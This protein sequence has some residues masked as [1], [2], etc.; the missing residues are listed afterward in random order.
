MNNQKIELTGRI[1]TPNSPDYNSAREAFN[2]FFNKFPLIIV[3]TQNTQDV[4]NAVRWS[5]LHNVPMRMRSGRHD[6]EALSVRN[7]G[8]VIDVNEM[9]K[10]EIDHNSG[11][12][13]I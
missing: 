10:L 11:T 12:V 8:L 6:Y 1:V 2:T 7:A 13:T 9:K 4:V 3:F 5:R